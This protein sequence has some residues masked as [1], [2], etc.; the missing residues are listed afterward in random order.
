VAGK[1]PA[2]TKL[3]RPRASDGRSCDQTSLALLPPIS[4]HP[5]LMLSRIFRP[6]ILYR[7]RP[8]AF[9][10]CRRPFHSALTLRV[11]SLNIRDHTNDGENPE[12]D[13]GSTLNQQPVHAVISTFDLFSIGVRAWLPLRILLLKNAATLG[14]SKQVNAIIAVLTDLEL[15]SPQFSHCWSNAGCEDFRQGPRRAKPT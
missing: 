6:N 13:T 5:L 4:V 1:R 7:A 15:I 9:V 8:T 2:T 12:A 11:P 10:S 3:I 14:W